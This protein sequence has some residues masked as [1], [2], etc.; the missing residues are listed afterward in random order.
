MPHDNAHRIRRGPRGHLRQR[1]A[2]D[3]LLR[4][5]LAAGG[6]ARLAL[7]PHGRGER[8]PTIPLE[9]ALALALDL[10]KINAGSG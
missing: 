2:Q 7:Y 1:A 9:R 5:A 6:G 4:K 10:R 8:P 3:R